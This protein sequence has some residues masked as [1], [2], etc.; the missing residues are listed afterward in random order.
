M[1]KV[2]LYIILILSLGACD[3]L[4]I[5]PDNVATIDNAFVDKYNAEK[6]LFT[7][8][9]YL[10]KM[11][12]INQNPALLGSDEVSKAV[13]HEN[14]NGIR[15]SNGYQ[16]PVNVLFNYWDG[17]NGGQPLYTGIR[18]CNTFIERIDGVPDLTD[19]EKKIWK[20]E[21][22]FIKAYLHFYLIR[23]YGPIHIIRENI[24]IN[25]S[26][27]ALKLSRDPIDECFNY[28]IE[29]IDEA[30]SDLPV[31]NENKTLEHGRITS[32]IA[33]GV[34]AKVLVTAA[35]PLF[36]G[37][38]GFKIQNLDGT[39]LFPSGDAATVA[40]KWE[41][42]ALA[43]QEAIVIAEEN[44]HRLLQKE[45]FEEGGTVSDSTRMKVVLGYRVSKREN[46]HEVIWSH[47]NSLVSGLQGDAMP[48]Y[49]SQLDYHANGNYGVPLKISL[50][51]YTQN[52]VPVSEDK[53]WQDVSVN[54]ILPTNDEH[55]YYLKLG[56][57]TVKRNFNRESRFYAD[58]IFDGALVYGH[59]R[60]FSNDLNGNLDYINHLQGGHTTAGYAHKYCP[61]GYWPKKL[62]NI[63]SG[64]AGQF[65]HYTNYA[66]PALRL[67]DLYLLYAE[68]LNE[69][70]DLTGAKIWIDKVR[71]RANL[72][73]VDESWQDYSI[74]SDKPG[75]KEGLRQIIHGE[76]L[77]E[78]AFEGSRFWDL[79]RWLEAEDHCNVPVQAWNPQE[80]TPE[81]YYEMQTLYYP[82]FSI[83][84]YFFPIAEDQLTK[85]PNLVQNYGW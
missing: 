26:I 37:E 73:G 21:A 60:T 57:R 3:Y 54:T 49:F 67:G 46:N 66:F 36:N 10:P 12:D 42:A 61:F 25:E 72:M 14:Q 5:V 59:Q 38:A 83:K 39:D 65:W 74:E 79:R 18:D 77:I 69:T 28:V 23:M 33:L 55:K 68:A 20:A 8:Y 58:L 1:K 16:T 15:L 53:D 43:C 82:E 62:V 51:Y 13:Y 84:H 32:V 80:S 4:D 85:N 56:R 44:G 22:K 6:Y 27:E 40:Q 76:R 78:M 48:Q 30:V 45:D 50:M 2:L 29:L 31:F 70:G 34:K 9:S 63:E 52:G 41:K 11:G 7:C 75:S 19:R 47:T 81:K 35:S 24:S 17:Y 71:E 64:E